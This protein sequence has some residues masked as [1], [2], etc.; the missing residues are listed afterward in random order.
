ME[1]PSGTGAEREAEADQAERYRQEARAFRDEAMERYPDS[2][3]EA[4]ELERTAADLVSLAVSIERRHRGLPPLPPAG[5]P[6]TTQ[7]ASP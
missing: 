5:L 4:K 6:A 7:E 3:T 1:D 2:P